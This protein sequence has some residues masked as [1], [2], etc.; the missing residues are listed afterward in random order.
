MF[1]QSQTLKSR[2]V[3]I[4]SRKSYN[5]TLFHFDNIFVRTHVLGPLVLL[6]KGSFNKASKLNFVLTICLKMFEKQSVHLGRD[7]EKIEMHG[8]VPKFDMYHALS[9]HESWFDF[10]DFCLK[11]LTSDRLLF[12]NS[13]RRQGVT[14]ITQLRA[15]VIKIVIFK[16]GHLMW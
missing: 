11:C 3:C 14:P 8:N 12:F 13:A 5:T 4:L 1:I 6:N 7:V 15:C 16:G 2:L 9:N 10:W